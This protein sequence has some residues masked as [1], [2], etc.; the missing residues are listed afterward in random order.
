METTEIKQLEK[1][2]LDVVPEEHGYIFIALPVGIPASPTYLSNM[3]RSDATNVMRNI[4]DVFN[5]AN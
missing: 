5:E 3:E 2:I 1:D 4:L